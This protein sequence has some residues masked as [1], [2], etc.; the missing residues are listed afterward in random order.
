MS[1]QTGANKSARAAV[2]AGISRAGSKAAYATGVA[3][4]WSVGQTDFQKRQRAAILA[5]TRRRARGAKTKIGAISRSPKTQRAI[6]NTAIGAGV[7]GVAAGSYILGKKLAAG[8]A[9][10]LKDTTAPSLL[11]APPVISPP[12]PAPPPVKSRQPKRVVRRYVNPER[13][14]EAMAD[15]LETTFDDIGLTTPSGKRLDDGRVAF[16]FG[17]YDD[18][19]GAMKNL[20][21]VAGEVQLPEGWSVEYEYGGRTVSK[22]EFQLSMKRELS[23]LKERDPKAYLS[24][25]RKLGSGQYG[26][27]PGPAR[28]YRNHLVSRVGTEGITKTLDAIKAAFE[29]GGIS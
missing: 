6:R 1:C 11:P 13:A 5:G 28:M 4:K 23:T 20:H 17:A 18:G 25:A 8:G 19:L 7:V 27:R 12:K 22:R 26:G 9:P 14:T 21:K 2:A 16:E 3:A 10:L 29:R 24:F 15:A